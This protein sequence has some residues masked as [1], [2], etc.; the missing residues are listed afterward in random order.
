MYFTL[1]HFPCSHYMRQILEALRYCHDNNVIHR[2]VKVPQLPHLSPVLNRLSL[3]ILSPVSS[4]HCL[5]SRYIFIYSLTS[6]SSPPTFSHPFLFS[7]HPPAL[8]LDKYRP[9]LGTNH[10]YT[11]TTIHFWSLIINCTY[12]IHYLFHKDIFK[13]SKCTPSS[14]F[15]SLCFSLFSLPFALSISLSLPLTLPPSLSNP[16]CLSSLTVCYWPPRRI[17]LQ[18]SWEGLEWPSSWVNPG[19]W[20]EVSRA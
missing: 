2:D 14:L 8:Y 15:P 3:P 9:F 12:Y 5:T 7:L 16:P 13:I 10:G 4:P 1:L 17:P 20:P 18:S 19:L 11:V 6:I